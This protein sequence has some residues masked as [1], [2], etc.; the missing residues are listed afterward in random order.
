MKVLGNTTHPKQGLQSVL[1]LI[2]NNTGKTELVAMIWLNPNPHFFVMATCGIGEG[3]K[4][5]CKCLC[6]LDNSCRALLDKVIIKVSQPKAIAKN[7]KGAGTIDRHN[8]IRA[9][10]LRMDRN[11]FTKHLEK[12]FNL[13]V[14]GIVCI[15]A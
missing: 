4:I 6:Q 11:L 5:S 7:Y 15:D 3:E 8:R 13:G 2:D 10:E 14:L 12:R 9:K 1:A